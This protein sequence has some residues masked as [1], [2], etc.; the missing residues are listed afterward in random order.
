MKAKLG[1]TI[2]LITSMLFWYFSKRQLSKPIVSPPAHFSQ[3]V[4]FISLCS[5]NSNFLPTF[6]LHVSDADYPNMSKLFNS[7]TN[8]TNAITNLSWSNASRFLYKDYKNFRQEFAVANQLISRMEDGLDIGFMQINGED[9]PKAQ[10]KQFSTNERMEIPLNHF[11]IMSNEIE[12]K[13]H[14]RNN[15]W[16]FHFKLMHF[17][18]LTSNY[19]SDSKLMNKTFTE[20]ENKLIK[21]YR[22]NP[23]QFPE[24]LAFFQVLFGDK[25]FE[26][27]YFN[28]KNQYVSYVT[29]INSVS[30]WKSSKN[31]DIDFSILKK[32]YQLRLKDL[33]LLV[34]KIL[35]YYKTIEQNTVLVVAGDHGETII[36]HDYFT[37]G[38]VPYDE[39]IRF[40][41]S[42]HFP[43]QT[44]K[45]IISEQISHRSTGHLIKNIAQGRYRYENLLDKKI[46]PV[47]DDHIM[48]FSC[49]GD[50]ASLRVKN[51]WKFIYF[52]N[53]D[54][55]QL[56][57][58]KADPL[59]T[60]DLSG[61]PGETE[62]LAIDLKIKVLEQISRRTITSTTCLR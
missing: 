31:S 39:V 57:D 48:S 1:F 14:S 40:F 4:L 51:K 3:N 20:E 42:V 7:S 21:L 9:D 23:E 16:M 18:Y 13:K 62:Q 19:F 59:E 5:V 44:S 52:L 2:L 27:L 32:S 8:Y 6:G 47:T 30:K 25:N 53:E 60:H 58:L 50:I 26:K 55:Y 49:A 35:N 43:N 61:R 28:R 10:Y 24:K 29:D 41:F 54:R 46:I 15:I 17:P 22:D 45:N 37:H 36:E 56:F 34:G 12:K 11:N 38:T 33:D